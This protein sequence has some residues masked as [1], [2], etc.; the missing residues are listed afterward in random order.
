ML[1]EGANFSAGE[2]QLRELTS[3]FDKTRNDQ[4]PVALVRALA[5]GCKVLLLDEATSSVDP[6][7]DK[8]I[9]TIIQT[10]F[11]DITVGHA[12][13]SLGVIANLPSSSSPSHIDFR[14]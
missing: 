6:E 5:R 12:K 1:N 4:L 13:F 8:M 2:R 11:R 3:P 9:Q 14:R 10:E 7:S